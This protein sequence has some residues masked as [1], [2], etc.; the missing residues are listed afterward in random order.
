MISVKKVIEAISEPLTY[1]YKLAFQTGK[2]PNKMKMAQVVPL[3][4]TGDRHHK[5]QACLSTTTI[6]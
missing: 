6:L 3:Y 1:I 2:F 4:K 5:L